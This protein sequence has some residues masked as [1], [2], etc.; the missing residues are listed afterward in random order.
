MRQEVI[1]KASALVAAFG[2]LKSAIDQGTADVKV[3][4]IFKEEVTNALK[5]TFDELALPLPKDIKEDDSLQAIETDFGNN[6]ANSKKKWKRKA[7][8]KLLEKI[9]ADEKMKVNGY[10]FDGVDYS[11]RT[12][13]VDTDEWSTTVNGFAAMELVDQNQNQAPTN[14]GFFQ[15]LG[16]HVVNTASN[17]WKTWI[18]SSLVNPWLS[19][20]SNLSHWKTGVEGKILLSDQASKT[21]CI[22]N[23][24]AIETKA[25]RTASEKY[26][27]QFKNKLKNLE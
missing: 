2:D 26:I 19:T 14:K 23:N 13:V 8:W 10:T 21:S 9:K 22:N 24:G 16:N 6:L 3:L 17:E 1:K 20:F 15:S 12:N 5:E 18:E 7:V 4:R 27:E 11:S 25:N